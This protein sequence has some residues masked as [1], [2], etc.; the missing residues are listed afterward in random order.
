MR[1]REA[2]PDETIF[3]DLHD[4]LLRASTCSS[5]VPTLSMNSL[6]VMSPSPPRLDLGPG[7]G[8]LF[9]GSRSRH[10]RRDRRSRGSRH[11]VVSR[12][13]ISAEASD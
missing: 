11:R 3:V 12:S 7:L 2:E 8:G 13:G 4:E 9:R 10:R 6:P 5:A 1:D